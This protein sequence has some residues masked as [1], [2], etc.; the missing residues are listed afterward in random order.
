MR[1]VPLGRGLARQPE[2]ERAYPRGRGRAVARVLIIEDDRDIRDAL[3]AVLEAEGHE[4][5]CA[6]NGREGLADA[7]TCMPDIILLDLMMPVMNGWQFRA[8]QKRDARISEIPVIVVTAFN[9][10]GELDVAAVILKPCDVDEVVG[11]VER[12]LRSS[13]LAPDAHP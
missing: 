3:E 6:G 12:H 10:V 5:T 2:Q 8:E 4:V 1:L 13:R 9:Q 11:A 7:R